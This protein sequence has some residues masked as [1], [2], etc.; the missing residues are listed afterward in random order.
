MSDTTS[1]DHTMATDV[2]A[3]SRKIAGKYKLGRILGEGGMGAVYEAEH[4]A[5]GTTVAIKL[6]SEANIGNEKSVKRFQREA[7]AM[8][9]IKHDNVIH[10]KDAGMDEDVPFLVME[11]LDGESLA[12]TLRRERV[13]SPGLASWIASET[14]A[15]LGAAHAQ[16]VIHRDLK[17]G[18]VFIAT[19]SDG[20]RRIK[21]LD[22]GISKLGDASATLNV[23]AEGALVGTPNFMAPEQ[24]R[25]NEGLDGR[26]DVYAAGIMLYR[27]VTGRLPYV[28]TNSEELYRRILIGEAK[29]PSEIRPELPKVLETVILKA[30]S[31]DREDRYQSTREFRDALQ[32]AMPGED[33][34][35]LRPRTT[36][37]PVRPAQNIAPR[38]Q[39][40]TVDLQTSDSDSF[41]VEEASVEVANLKKKSWSWL[42]IAIVALGAVLGGILT[43]SIVR[44]NR[45]KETQ[46]AVTALEEP[47]YLGMAR[48]K[49]PDRIRREMEPLLTYLSS[50]VG[51]PIVLKLVDN[52]E[53]FAE[54]LQD[55]DLDI[56]ALSAI[57]YIRAERRLD[58][59]RLLATPTT[60]NG[61]TYGAYIL[62]RADSGITKLQ[63][64]KGKSFCF[65]G[66]N[67][68]SGYLYPRATFRKAGI[69]PDKSL[70]QRIESDHDSSLR[71][72]LKGGCEGAAVYDQAWFDAQ[73]EG[74]DPSAFKV[75]GGASRVPWDAYCV[76]SSVSREISDKLETALLDLK[77]GS[78]LANEVLVNN[79]L[80]F[81][82]FQAG[83]DALYDSVRSI[84]KYLNIEVGKS[85]K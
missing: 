18:N 84:E 32:D 64:F 68:S 31:P 13:L 46:P 80:P 9:A 43:Y 22:F 59:L 72:L 23:T 36:T 20:S 56:A 44:D 66:E 3:P 21:I 4:P 10:V 41:I 1:K 16:G 69:D 26:I 60:N 63:H 11:L 67:S 39:S 52:Y 7:K 78:K 74:I 61:P 79:K 75:I 45:T 29:P 51:R 57:N 70:R 81:G 6:L 33:Y 17:P 19:Q 50:R 24:I 27:M 65:L 2:L 25:A 34:G 14:L 49:D 5:L 76:T 77:K 28:G 54:R 12:A 82:G 71:A 55:G 85:H 42:A 8:A 58:N 15:G 73:Q 48:H 53:D 47:L 35:G 37:N 30:M 40:A 83:D 62:A 38:L